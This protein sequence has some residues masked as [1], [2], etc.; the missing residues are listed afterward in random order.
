MNDNNLESVAWQKL[1]TRE[2]FYFF[3]PK[4][5]KNIE[6]YNE[7]FELKSLFPIN[8][9]GIVTA[10]DPLV[11][12]THKEDL[13]KRI[14]YFANPENTDDQVREKFF[15][16]KKEKKYKKGDTRGWKL[17][18]ARKK[19]RNFD[20]D[21]KIQKVNYRPFDDCWIYYTPEMVDWGREDVMK[22]ML[23][24]HNIGLVVCRQCISDNW[25]HAF[26][27]NILA[28]DSYVSNKSKERGYVMPLYRYEAVMGDVEQKVPNF[29]PAI[30]SKIKDAVPDITPESLFDYIYAVLHAPAYRER[31]AEFLK[32]DFPRIPYPDDPAIFHVLA[33]K[34]A[35]IREL[36]LLESPLLDDTGVTYPVSGNN[37]VDTINK[38][39]FKDGKVFINKDQYFDGVSVTAWNF[40]SAAINRRKNG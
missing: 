34:G 10:R 18:A 4:T 2:P 40:I 29:D 37:E 12:D 30:Y 23:Q 11:I 9:T 24:E 1:D 33:E 17:D 39:S 14:S 5:Y 16:H 7:G 27:A 22:H 32:S 38:N 35:A 8:V 36:H 26:I 31:Y 15:G 21:S 6:Q 25:S 13:N 19:I 28:D 3:I 20:H